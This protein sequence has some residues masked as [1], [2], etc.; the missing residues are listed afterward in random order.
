MAGNPYLFILYLSYLFSQFVCI[1][2]R[3]LAIYK[4]TSYTIIMLLGWGGYTPLGAL[5]L[6]CSWPHGKQ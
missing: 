3:N 1:T 6:Y 2:N 4:K 5:V